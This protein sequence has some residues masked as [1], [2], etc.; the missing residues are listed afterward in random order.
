VKSLLKSGKVP[1]LSFQPL[2][3]FSFF[4]I[5]LLVCLI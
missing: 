2:I 3:N 4:S 5:L 1:Q